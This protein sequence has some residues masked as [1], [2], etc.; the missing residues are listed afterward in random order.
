VLDTNVVMSG[1][2]FGGVPGRTLA[3]W[4]DRRIVPVYTPLIYHEYQRVAKAL[5]ARHP[6]RDADSMLALFLTEG[7][8]VAD[9][10]RDERIS[11]DPDD[12]KFVACALSSGTSVIASGDK[13]LLAVD[14]YEGVEVLTPR[15]LL[16]R[17]LTP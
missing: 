15:Q 16:N 8:L 13:H 7:I 1:I 5:R 3:A 17:H 12:D 6:D 14:G 4:R 10:P 2:F 9:V 11:E